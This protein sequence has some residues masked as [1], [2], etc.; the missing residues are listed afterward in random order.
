LLLAI[1]SKTS[2]SSGSSRD[3][4][5]DE[6]QGVAAKPNSAST[7]DGHKPSGQREEPIEARA[8]ATEFG[9]LITGDRVVSIGDVDR[10]IDGKHDAVVIYDVASH[11]IGCYPAFSKAKDETIQALQNFLGPHQAVRQFYS[12][13]SCELYAAAGH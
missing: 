7:E 1:A 13:A 3:L 2:S 10:S 6:S 11:F 5:R 4:P 9:D 12:D 8:E